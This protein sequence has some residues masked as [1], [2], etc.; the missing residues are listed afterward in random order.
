MFCGT[1]GFRGTP[2]EENWFTPGLAVF[3]S[4][5]RE[6]AFTGCWMIPGQFTFL[7]LKHDMQNCCF[8]TLTYIRLNF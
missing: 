6:A 1:L 5:L 8:V 2:V 7:F 3:T 4:I